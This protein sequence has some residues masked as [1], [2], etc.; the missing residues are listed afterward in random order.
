MQLLREYAQPDYAR[1]IGNNPFPASQLIF[2]PPFY[3][4]AANLLEELAE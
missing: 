1:S 2:S 3:R 4:S